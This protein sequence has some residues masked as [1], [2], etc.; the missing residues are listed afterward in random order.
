MV[1]PKTTLSLNKTSHKLSVATYVTWVPSSIRAALN[2]NGPLVGTGSQ[3]SKPSLEIW[4][5]VLS[6]CNFGVSC[7]LLSKKSD[8]HLCHILGN[9]WP[10]VACCARV[11][12]GWGCYVKLLNKIAQNFNNKISHNSI[13][14]ILMNFHEILVQDFLQSLACGMWP[15]TGLKFKTSAVSIF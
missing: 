3:V 10:I 14:Q 4:H 6:K 12:H 2:P 5:I 15:F 9:I 1:K 11:V 8:F 7:R 13:F